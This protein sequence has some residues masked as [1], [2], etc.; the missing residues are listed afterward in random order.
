MPE[1]ERF[2]AKRE[3]AVRAGQ[4]CAPMALAAI[5]APEGTLRISLGPFNTEDDVRAI[6]AAVD[7]AIERPGR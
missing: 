5:G 4:H 3:I 6:L 7:E 1:A 2:F